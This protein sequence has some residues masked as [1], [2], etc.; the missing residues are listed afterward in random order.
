ME[1]HIPVIKG[2]D[3]FKH[4]EDKAQTIRSQSFTSPTTFLTNLHSLETLHEGAQKLTI[5]EE[6]KG[7][8]RSDC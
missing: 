7:Q 2:K 4:S 1:P 8:E 6:E 3:L 5:T